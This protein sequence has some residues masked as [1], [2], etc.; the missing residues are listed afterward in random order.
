MG[1]TLLILGLLTGALA[2]CG[3]DND[4]IG[5]TPDPTNPTTTTGAA[6]TV[7][8]HLE[9]VEGV[10]VEGF[11]IGLRFEIA[12]GTLIAS[13]LWTDFVRSLGEP[14]LQDFYDSVL[15]QPVPAGTVIVRAQV[16]V[17]A[18]PPPVTPDLDGDFA[19]RLDID[20]PADGRVEVEVGFSGYSDCL[21]AR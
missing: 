14:T 7:A 5:T 4:T 12:D 10:F 6:G 2:A 16:N 8:V 17:G 20:V 9:P 11:Q 21:R 13:T 1:R 18:G 15:E 3:T 19:C